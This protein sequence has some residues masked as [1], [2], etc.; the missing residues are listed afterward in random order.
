M[1]YRN[2][3]RKIGKVTV[4]WSI[5]KLLLWISWAFKM[6]TNILNYSLNWQP[7]KSSGD[8]AE[9]TM[10]HN[11]F[12]PSFIE[13]MHNGTDLST[14]CSA[15]CLCLVYYMLLKSLQKTLKENFPSFLAT[16]IPQF[17]ET[18]ILFKNFYLDVRGN[19][20]F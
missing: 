2:E 9:R 20:L 15:D 11:V 14:L 8:K 3:G 18:L 6:H 10:G 1:F 5:L 16:V 12:L 4:G 19:T 13:S 17:M 7:N